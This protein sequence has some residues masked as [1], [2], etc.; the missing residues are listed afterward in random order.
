[1]GVNMLSPVMKLMFSRPLLSNNFLS[2]KLWVLLI[3]SVCLASAISVVLVTAIDAL[4]GNLIITAVDDYYIYFGNGMGTMV[5]FALAVYL[6]PNADWVENHINESL[7]SYRAMR[8]SYRAMRLIMFGIWHIASMLIVY[9][10]LVPNSGMVGFDWPSE[11]GA[12]LAELL[13]TIIGAAFFML[14]CYSDAKGP[15]RS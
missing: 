12:A 2:L 13:T 5:F 6:P 10:F 1:M 9:L 14:I 3:V 15:K 4:G 8:R 11:T 7:W